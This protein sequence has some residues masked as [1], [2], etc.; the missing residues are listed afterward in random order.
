[1]LNLGRVEIRGCDIAAQGNIQWNKVGLNVRLCYTYQKAQDF[2][3]P[4]E[5]YYGD[6]I[7]YI[8][9]H[10]GSVLLARRLEKME[11]QLQFYLHGRTLQPIRKYDTYPLTAVVHQRSIGQS[12]IRHKTGKL[13]NNGRDKQSFQPILRVVANYPMPGNQLQIILRVEI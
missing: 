8:P 13:S 4:E 9:H 2:T 10:S 3:D 12:H 7:P 5:N 1:M 11:F 6:Q